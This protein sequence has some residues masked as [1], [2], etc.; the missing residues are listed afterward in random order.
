MAWGQGGSYSSAAFGEGMSWTNDAEPWNPLAQTFAS[1]DLG[2]DQ[3]SPSYQGYQVDGRPQW[4]PD[5]VA[6]RIPQSSPTNTHQHQRGLAVN[7][8]VQSDS[9]L[10]QNIH[11]QGAAA[12][13]EDATVYMSRPPSLQQSGHGHVEA[14]QQGST[15]SLTTPSS[16][17]VPS[18]TFVTD[19][20]PYSTSLQGFSAH[21]HVN[22]ADDR[23][24]L[25]QPTSSP[26]DDIDDGLA[27]HRIDESGPLWRSGDT[28]FLSP[29]SQISQ[30]YNSLNSVGNQFKNGGATVHGTLD[31]QRTPSVQSIGTTCHCGLTQDD[32]TDYNHGLAGHQLDHPKAIL[33]PVSSKRYQ[34]NQPS[35]F[36]ITHGFYPTDIPSSLVG[37]P[38][39]PQHRRRGN[40]ISTP[41]PSSQPM[42]RNTSGSKSAMRSRTDSLSIIQ[43]NGQ[44]TLALSSSPGSQK[45]RRYKPLNPEARERA[46]QKRSEKSVCVRCKMMKQT[47][48]NLDS[49]QCI[50]A[51]GQIPPVQRRNTL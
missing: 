30:Q 26:I 27:Q 25:V 20:S 40:T 1:S 48:S 43:E 19:N 11:S 24:Q 34:S 16:S 31:L 5:L 10:A 6:P 18:P 14:R 28:N 12:G 7:F 21:R 41:V 51:N 4:S 36:P 13:F 17:I 32:S 45:G 2:Y 29:H 39:Q 35:S 50:L 49:G 46:R 8:G 22:S 37:H 38:S 44:K 47:A 42:R 15:Q 23:A 3:S 9:H 33:I